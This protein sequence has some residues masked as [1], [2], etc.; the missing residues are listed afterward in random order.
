MLAYTSVKNMKLGKK[1]VRC[2]ASQALLPQR[3]LNN[4]FSSEMRKCKDV[5]SWLHSIRCYYSKAI[6]FTVITQANR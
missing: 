6:S 4:H 1:G 3:L 2:A 5:F